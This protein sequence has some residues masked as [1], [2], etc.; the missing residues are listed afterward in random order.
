M[1]MKTD[2]TMSNTFQERMAERM[3]ES[4]GELLS[5]ED[6]KKIIL[7]GVEDTFFTSKTNNMGFRTIETKPEFQKIVKE[8]MEEYI[9]KEIKNIVL[10]NSADIGDKI[11]EVL[12]QEIT[13]TIISGFTSYISSDLSDLKYRLSSKLNL[14]Y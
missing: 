11:K 3:R 13:K 9:R 10:E 8:E 7:K 4:I 2:L 1:N 14:N 6:L 12:E 5:G